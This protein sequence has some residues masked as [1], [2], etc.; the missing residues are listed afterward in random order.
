LRI[1]RAALE[2]RSFSFNSMYGAC[3]ECHGLGSNMTFD[4]AKVINDWSKPLLD[5]GLGPGSAS[6]NLIHMPANFGGSLWHRILNTPFEKFSERR[7]IFLLNGE[8]GAWREDWFS[9][10]LRISETESGGVGFRRISRLVDGSHAATQC[11]AC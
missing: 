4:P 10:H 7:K 5:G 1:K 8:P 3:P 2:P 11:P 6:Q 9:R